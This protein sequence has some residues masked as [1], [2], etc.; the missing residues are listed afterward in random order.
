[1]QLSQL[2]LGNDP[3]NVLP[4]ITGHWLSGLH[5]HCL[6]P[7]LVIYQQ[8]YTSAPWT[9][10]P[11]ICLPLT[12]QQ[13]GNGQNHL[14]SRALKNGMSHTPDGKY[15]MKALLFTCNVFNCAPMTEGGMV[16]DN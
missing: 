12:P 8:Q 14:F 1:L 10:L 16:P 11:Q 2:L 3:T 9:Q 7:T 4:P 15:P 13:E 6:F 5:K